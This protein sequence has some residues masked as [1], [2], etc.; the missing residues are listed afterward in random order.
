MANLPPPVLESTVRRSPWLEF[1]NTFDAGHVMQMLVLVAAVI[2][3]A[4]TFSGR[5]VALEKDIGNLS[6]RVTDEQKRNGDVLR[7]LRLDVLRQM[8]DLKVELG[9]VSDKL[10]RKAD[11]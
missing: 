3:F 8:Q 1:R 2:G 9:K 6:L 7:D 4:M 11:K 10:D 5:L